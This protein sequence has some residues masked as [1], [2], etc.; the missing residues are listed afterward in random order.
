[1]HIMRTL[2]GIDDL[3]VH[4]M[5]NDAIFIADAVTAQ[6]IARGTRNIQC[7]AA[8]IPLQNRRDFHRRRALVF[9]TSEA[10]AALQAQRDFCLHI[11]QFFLHQLGRCQRTSK[12]LAIQRVLT[13]G[14]PAEFRCT[15][16]PPSDAV[17]R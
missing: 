6:H 9:H 16:G 8:G 3:K 12:L 15:Q 2:V 7:L 4:Y 1:M 13:R 10:Q 17:T 11:S 14:V 5:A